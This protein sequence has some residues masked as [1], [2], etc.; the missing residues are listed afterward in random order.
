MAV[1]AVKLSSTLVIKVIT[2][3]DGSGNDVLKSISLKNI[4]P[5]TLEQ[6]MHDVAQAIAAVLNYPINGY[7]RQNLDELIS[8]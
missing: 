5:E 8:A 7:F 4:K 1:T 3:T 6:D 2:G